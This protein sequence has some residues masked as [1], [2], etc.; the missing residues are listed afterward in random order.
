MRNAGSFTRAA[1]AVQG[2]SIDTGIASAPLPWPPRTSGRCGYDKP[3]EA[4]APSTRP[5]K[6]IVYSMCEG[7]H[8]LNTAAQSIIAPNGLGSTKPKRRRRYHE[9]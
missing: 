3:A 5:D 1:R 9:H 4:G 6:M 8:T 2:H 7:D